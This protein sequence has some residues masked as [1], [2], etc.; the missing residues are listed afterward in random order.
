MQKSQ[1]LVELG[2]GVHGND[3]G[4]FEALRRMNGDDR[5]R[6]SVRVRAALDLLFAVVPIVTKGLDESHESARIISAG[7]LEE[8]LDIGQRP[9]GAASISRPQNRAHVQLLDRFRDQLVRRGV[10]RPPGETLQH[11]ERATEDRVS[12]RSAIDPKMQA[13]RRIAGRGR[14]GGDGVGDLFLGESDEGAAQESAQAERVAPIRNGAGESDQ[15][16]D[17]LAAEKTLA[18]LRGDRNA[19]PFQRAF[20]NPEARAGWSQAAP[21]LRKEGRKTAR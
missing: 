16:L 3:D 2:R 15:I 17:F 4:P 18:G 11:L 21:V 12:D 7:H 6:F 9:L 1:I 14:K 5:H 8:E 20:V 13:W 10:T 19:A